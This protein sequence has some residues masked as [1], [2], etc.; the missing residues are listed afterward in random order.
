MTVQRV[1][2]LKLKTIE[3]DVLLP[4][5]TNKRLSKTHQKLISNAIQSISNVWL[6]K[7]TLKLKKEVGT[8]VIS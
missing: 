5:N 1:A 8:K 6:G 4:S 3:L 2:H 7:T